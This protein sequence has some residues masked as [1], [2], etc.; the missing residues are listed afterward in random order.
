MNM[1]VRDAAKVLG[2]PAGTLRRWL[3]AG[4]PVSRRGARGRGLATLVDPAA[5]DAWRAAPS[6]EALVMSIAA[7]LPDVVADAVEESHRLSEGIDRQAL[8][9]VLAGTWYVVATRAMD[10]LRVHCASVPEV[11]AVPAQIER[12]R[13]IAH[14]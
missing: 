13:K 14:R 4:A 1:P 2:V 11:S 10:A 9:R 6:H 5:V 7:A 3:R 12:L 8:A